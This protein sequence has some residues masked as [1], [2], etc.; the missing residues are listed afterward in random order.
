L[1]AARR[2]QLAELNAR[3]RTYTLQ[4]WAVPL[5]YFGVIAALLA[6]GSASFP[7]T[8]RELLGSV[9]GLFVLWHLAGVDDGRSR[10][11]TALRDT[12]VRLGLEPSAENRP[13]YVWP[14]IVATAFVAGCLFGLAVSQL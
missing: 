11:V 7:L 6:G 4:M 1:E 2:T 5:G 8:A 13:R 3:A 14:L 10:A 12:E 9:A